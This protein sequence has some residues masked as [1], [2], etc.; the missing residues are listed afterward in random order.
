MADNKVCAYEALVRWNKN[1]KILYPNEFIPIFEREST[2]CLLD[3]YVLEKVCEY[4]RQ[5]L[6]SGKTAVR[7]FVNF[8]K[9]HLHNKCIADDI[10]S[11]IEN[12]DIWVKNLGE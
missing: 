6:D 2:I 1:G 9:I 3:F 4:T 10:I 5:R 11:I 7:T 8:S 12:Y